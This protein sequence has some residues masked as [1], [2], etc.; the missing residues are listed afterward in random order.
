MFHIGRAPPQNQQGGRKRKFTDTTTSPSQHKF[1]KSWLL[2]P[3]SKLTPYQ[4]I[5]FS[6]LPQNFKD[7][8]AATTDLESYYSESSK[9]YTYLRAFRK[10]ELTFEQIQ[11]QIQEAFEKNQRLRFAFKR[12]LNAWR[13]KHV[14]IVNTVDIV[15]QEP[16]QKLVSIYD[17]NLRKCYQFE[18]STILRDSTLRLLN[19]DSL[20]MESLPPRNILTN[21]NFTEGQCIALYAQMK[22]HGITNSHW[23]SFAKCGFST[24]KLVYKYEVPMRLEIME[25]LFKTYS[26]DSA[27]MIVDFVDGQYRELNE[28]VPDESFIFYALKKHW[29]HPYVRA[30]VYLCRKYWAAQIRPHAFTD[31]FRT[32]I[33]SESQKM[34]HHKVTW[35]SLCIIKK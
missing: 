5:I 14:V 16:I 1:R 32:Y 27:D 22:P 11:K 30:W 12:I 4:Q 35:H 33:A 18:A 20:M 31:A 34:I 19:H 21:T 25:T 28:L 23:E 7:L 15:T 10:T 17:W 8:Y 24:K 2:I 29:E 3:F 9:E 6:H 13:F 26:W